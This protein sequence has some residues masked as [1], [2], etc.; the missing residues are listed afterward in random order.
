MIFIEDLVG[1]PGAVD[2]TK[3]FNKG[4][5]IGLRKIWRESTIEEDAGEE[6]AGEKQL[7][8]HSA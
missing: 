6:D 5:T 8:R 3:D 1:D 7:G 2:A 4:V